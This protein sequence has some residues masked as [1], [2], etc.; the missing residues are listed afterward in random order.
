MS[1][2]ARL[3]LSTGTWAFDVAPE[4]PSPTVEIGFHHA[5]RP[6]TFDRLTFGLTVVADGTIHLTKAYPPSGVR[7]VSTDQTYLTTDR[8]DLTADAEV[9]LAVWAENGGT[10]HEAQT[11]FVVPRPDQPYPSWSWEDGA[12]VAPITYPDDG[13]IYSW[14]EDAGSWTPADTEA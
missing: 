12:W 8:V 3:D 7:Y 9:T 14:D 4:S 5:D 6:A 2:L 11:T 1:V 13:G 10:R